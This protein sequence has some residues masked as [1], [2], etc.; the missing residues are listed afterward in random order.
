MW[1][2]DFDKKILKKI[3]IVNELNYSLTA[4]FDFKN[5][6]LVCQNLVKIL[7]DDLNIISTIEH[8][9]KEFFSNILF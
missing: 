3:K 4:I 8:D 9:V 6:V 2:V 7:D 1:L 5:I